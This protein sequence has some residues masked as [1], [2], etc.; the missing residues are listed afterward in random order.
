MQ[1]KTEIERLQSCLSEMTEKDFSEYSIYWGKK[2]QSVATAII[3]EFARD[4][5][6]IIDPF[7]GGGSTIYG[8]LNSKWK[9]DLFGSDVNEQPI[10]QAIFNLQHCNENSIAEADRIFQQFVEENLESYVYYNSQRRKYI[11][12]KARVDIV[13]NLPNLQEIWLKD[14]NKKVSS[15]ISGDQEFAQFEEQYRERQTNL[16]TGLDLDLPVNSRIAIKSGMKISHL[17][18]PVNFR[19]LLKLRELVTEVPY[20]N[21]VLSSVLHLCKYTDKG[22]QSQFPFWYP[23]NDAYERNIL[24]LIEKKH[25][26]ISANVKS[27]GEKSTTSKNSSKYS[28]SKLPIQH[29]TDKFDSNTFDL[30]I[31]DP[32]YFDQVAYSEYLITWEFFT[33]SKID[34]QNEIVESN[35]VDS[36]QN[37]ER[38][39]SEMTLGFKSLRQVSKNNSLMF[40]YYKDVR[41]GN[42]E[43]ILRI[44]AQSGWAFK[45]QI[46]IDRKQ[47]TYKQNSSKRNTVEGDCLIILEAQESHSIPEYIEMSSGELLSKINEITRKYLQEHGASTLST[48]YDNA[49][50]PFLFSNGLLG[51]FKSPGDIANILEEQFETSIETRKM[52]VRN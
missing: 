25:K 21:G 32:P 5:F 23:K 13:E 42:I 15:F 41:L 44:L 6:K 10:H 11:F 4:G 14:E 27:R 45:G 50:V 22:S 52:N 2:S 34:L 35:R 28:L 16:P 38:Y 24:E 31:T 33:G 48:V 30:V 3:N 8:A 26:T 39:L 36:N 7:L 9:L 46:H 40:L 37:R 1:E 51:K 17:Y 19:I 18:S 20:L 43:A 47:F 12:Q 49:L 29:L